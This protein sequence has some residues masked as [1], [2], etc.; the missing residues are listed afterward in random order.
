MNINVLLCNETTLHRQQQTVR[1]ILILASSATPERDVDCS[2]CEKQ[3]SGT[4]PAIAGLVHVCVSG[5]TSKCVPCK[6]VLH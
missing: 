1:R 2:L 5:L 6:I 4:M 3:A